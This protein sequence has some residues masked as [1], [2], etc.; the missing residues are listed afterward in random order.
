MAW[1]NGNVNFRNRRAL[2]MLGILLLAVLIWSLHSS[3]YFSVQN[4]GS[5]V[6]DLRGRDEQRR[7]EAQ[8]ALSRLGTNAVPVLWRYYT[9]QDPV[10]PARL[11][12]WIP[13]IRIR[14]S[15]ADTR[16]IGYEG[17]RALGS[18]AFPVSSNLV[19]E[20]V[21]SSRRDGRSVHLL[22][23][24]GSSAV[25]DIIASIRSAPPLARV[26]LLYALASYRGGAA[27]A[28]PLVT[29]MLSDPDGAVRQAAAVALGQIR[30]DAL[31]VVPELA[32]GLRDPNREVRQ[33]V[34]QSL[35]AYGT[36]SV[37]VIPDLLR[38]ASITGLDDPERGDIAAALI[39]TRDANTA[40]P[41][42][43][44]L[45]ESRNLTNRIWAITNLTE[46]P[47]PFAEIGRLVAR[48]INDPD[49][50]LSVTSASELGQAAR[51]ASYPTPFVDAGLGATLPEA[52]L[53]FLKTAWRPDHG[54]L[55]H[56][57]RAMGDGDARVRA[58][59]AE[60]LIGM[61]PP[62]LAA[63]HAL[64]RLLDDPDYHVRRVAYHALHNTDSDSFPAP[65]DWQSGMEGEKRFI[66]VAK[67]H[68]F[69]P[70]SV[71]DTNLLAAARTNLFPSFARSL[72]LAS[73][74][75]NPPDIPSL[76]SL[77][78][79]PDLRASSEA[80]A[81]LLRLSRDNTDARQALVEALA[82][83]ET[84]GPGAHLALATFTPRNQAVLL[85]LVARAGPRVRREALGWLLPERLEDRDRAL[86][87]LM[88]ASRDLDL[89]VA[90][91]AKTLLDKM[92]TDG[93]AARTPEAPQAQKPASR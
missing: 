54:I 31:V 10:W 50:N 65:I 56:T 91:M 20:V 7:M 82:F 28:T 77:V 79:S 41:E 19:Q 55:P 48:F 30:S 35:A 70:Q 52:R 5:I 90:S 51:E 39:S 14:V 1:H 15:R 46:V 83:G 57:I 49:A 2:G 64:G 11:N 8:D 12:R 71:T 32:R 66:A 42:V 27:V 68:L 58:A 92:G 38:L 33:A 18:S 74:R 23:C 53:A 62:A 89:P 21:R 43:L 47:I 61:T 25:P 6:R 93:K 72:A 84:V 73:S 34:L 86:S 29:K 16:E 67:L 40:R 76:K 17:L 44:A 88:K 3:F 4:A 87:V 75:S 13:F 22:F 63:Q 78:A 69:G 45:L 9:T 36:N 26:D 60:S 37:S 59:A 24:I 81:S 85:D 80:T